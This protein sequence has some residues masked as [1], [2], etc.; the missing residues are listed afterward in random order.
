MRKKLIP[1]A[2]SMA[3]VFATPLMAQ[4]VVMERTQEPRSGEPAAAQAYQKM[5]GE[6]RARMAVEAKITPG[7][8]YSA[9]AVTETI[10]VLAARISRRRGSYAP[11][12][13][14]RQ[15]HGRQHFD[16]RSGRAPELCPR[17]IVPHRVS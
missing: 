2:L 8:P 14:G 17:S 7:A 4:T 5:V 6:V 13:P 11:R 3:I 1:W 16:R 10:Q 15:R 12:R 9:E